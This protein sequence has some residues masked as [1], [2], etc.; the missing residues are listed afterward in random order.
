MALPM[1]VLAAEPWDGHELKAVEPGDRTE[2]YKLYLGLFKLLK[3]AHTR[4]VQVRALADAAEVSRVGSALT[5]EGFVLVSHW[6]GGRPLVPRSNARTHARGTQFIL[7]E[8]NVRADLT[9]NR[10]MRRVMKTSF[11]IALVAFGVFALLDELIVPSWSWIIPVASVW[12]VSLGVGL[13]Y[14]GAADFWS[15]VIVVALT[16]TLGD[17]VETA[18][19]DSVRCTLSIA[20]SGAVVR[21]QNYKAVSR[22]SRGRALKRSFDVG[23]AREGVEAVAARLQVADPPL[24]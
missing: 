5:A 2:P 6:T 7:G 12:G 10:L 23:E 21:A 14:F 24:G 1:G 13:E 19:S 18:T 4:V 9:R 17:R 8:R 16:P 22:S 11:V 15:E 20:V 3:P